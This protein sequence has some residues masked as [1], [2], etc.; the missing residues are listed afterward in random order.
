MIST[1]IKCDYCGKDIITDGIIIDNF[2]YHNKCYSLFEKNIV[3]R[4]N[5]KL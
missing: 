4:K 2:H 3:K 5:E 1:T